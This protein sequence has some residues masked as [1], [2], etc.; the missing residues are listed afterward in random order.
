[1]SEEK[2]KS[3][4]SR[5]PIVIQIEPD[6]LLDFQ[7]GHAQRRRAKIALLDKQRVQARAKARTIIVR[8]LPQ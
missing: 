6:K 3:D 5:R 7:N 1:M 2:G 8:S 4:P